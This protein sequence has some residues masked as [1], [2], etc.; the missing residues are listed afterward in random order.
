[1]RDIYA[2]IHPSLRDFMIIPR[3]RHLLR[4]NRQEI[5]DGLDFIYTGSTNLTTHAV[6]HTPN[7]PPRVVDPLSPTGVDSKMTEVDWPIS[8]WCRVN[9]FLVSTSRNH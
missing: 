2:Y 5:K 1:M 4:R 9:R 8:F 6:R 7:T 3:F